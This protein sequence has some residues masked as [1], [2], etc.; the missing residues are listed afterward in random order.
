M[1]RTGSEKPIRQRRA[2]D[3]VLDVIE[4]QHELLIRDRFGEKRPGWLIEGG[5][6][7]QRPGDR[8]RQDLRIGDRCQLDEPDG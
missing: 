2:R 1:I 7:P 4:H 3:Q 6:E 5:F 8:S